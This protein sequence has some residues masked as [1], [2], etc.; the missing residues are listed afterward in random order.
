MDTPASDRLGAGIA[1][2]IVHGLLAYALLL[3]LTGKLPQKTADVLKVFNVTA[4]PPPPPV[5]PPPQPKYRAH[6]GR[7]SPANLHAKP[8]EIVKPPPRV[9]LVVPPPIA[10]APVAGPGAQSSAGAS[11]VRGP[12]TG[13]GGQG[14]GLGSGGEGNGFGG[15]F[16]PIQTKGD[17]KF[18]R[19]PFELSHSGVTR[20]GVSIYIQ[21][22]GRV[23]DCRV[24]R[25]SGNAQ[26]DA[27]TCGLILQRFRFKPPH[28]AQ[29]NHG[30]WWDNDYSW[31]I[32][33]DDE[34]GPDAR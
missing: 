5:T 2:A 11:N 3:G 28:D 16:E 1:V 18:S 14:N 31:E 10:A 13:A 32:E 29:G 19:Y 30:G 15:D 17:L 12:G 26:F 8:T 23:S 34:K 4:P 24:K 22:D 9:P 21:A 7:A 33:E 6:A 20:I 25:S 27:T